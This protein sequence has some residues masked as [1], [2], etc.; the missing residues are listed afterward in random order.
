MNAINLILE[1][2]Q[3]KIFYL[4]TRKKIKLKG[5]RIKKKKETNK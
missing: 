5:N 1:W 3:S 2:M 4:L